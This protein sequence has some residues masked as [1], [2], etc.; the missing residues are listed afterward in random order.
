[1]I[2]TVIKNILK[3]ILSIFA[4]RHNSQK[5]KAV[6]LF[7]T[8]RDKEDLRDH[9]YTAISEPALIKHRIPNLPPIRNQKSIGSCAS[10]AV[11]AAYEIQLLNSSKRQ[12]IEGSE[13]FHYYYARKN[14]GTFPKDTGMT[15]RQACATM[16]IYGMALEYIWPYSIDK[17]NTEPN[18]LAKVFAS[19]Y[20]IKE[21]QKLLSINDVENSIID[22]IPVIIGLPMSAPFFR[23]NRDNY[24]FSYNGMSQGGHAIL[25]VGM[26]KERK[27]F[28]VRNSW[29][30]NWG[31]EGYFEITYEDFEKYAFDSW[32][33]IN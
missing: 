15:I 17:Y 24:T 6:M 3:N 19:L 26:D 20:K 14:A 18:N 1:M 31:H 7:N 10:H 33:I 9:I 11:I 13:L 22:N 28:E 25:V 21:Y 23:L 32:R 2:K 29:G 30:M 12:Y 5:E 27:V 16:S 8:I 4:R